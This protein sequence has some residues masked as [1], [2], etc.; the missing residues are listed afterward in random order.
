MFFRAPEDYHRPALLADLCLGTSIAPGV[1]IRLS[2]AHLLSPEPEG[3]SSI[4][5]PVL[6]E[7]I[8]RR[9]SI[10]YAAAD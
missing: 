8:N 2:S 3:T 4:A 7:P 6:G 10:A 5:G 1:I 9:I